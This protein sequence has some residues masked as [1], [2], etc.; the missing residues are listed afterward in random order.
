MGRPS[1][2]TPEKAEKI[3]AELAEGKS[4][5]TVC[6]AEDMPCKETVF[7]WIGNNEEFRRQ[8]VK[9]KEE[10]S[11]A[12]FEETLDIADETLEVIRSGEERKANAY[13]Q[14]NKLRVD[15]RKW[16]MSKMKPKK[17]GDK[18]DVTTAGKELPAPL[19]AL[20]VLRNH[21]AEETSEAEKKD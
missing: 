18:M 16:M 9:A 14:A 1:E 7:R 10:A 6:L 11:D 4:L 21:S 12:L 2:Y 19:I 5:R 3:C 20:D 13:A 15:T 17:Y 8:Y